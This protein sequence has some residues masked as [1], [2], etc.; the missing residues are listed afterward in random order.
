MSDVIQRSIDLPA[1]PRE[2][3]PLVASPAWLGEGEIDPSPGAEGWVEDGDATRYLVVEEVDEPHRLTY[4][5]ASFADEPTRV[6]IDLVPTET[7]TRVTVT[8]GPL[9]ATPPVELLAA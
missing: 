1:A 5:W 9:H 7:G 6:E 3:W 4:R 8:E 2:V